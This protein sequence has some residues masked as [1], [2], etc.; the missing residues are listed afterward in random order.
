MTKTDGEVPQNEKFQMEPGSTDDDAPQA[1]KPLGWKQGMGLYRRQ[2][3]VESLTL[4]VGSMVLLLYS[5]L[6]LDPSTESWYRRLH[7]IRNEFEKLRKRL[8]NQ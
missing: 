3:T 1:N 6:T 2:K 8:A 4:D 7:D 5:T